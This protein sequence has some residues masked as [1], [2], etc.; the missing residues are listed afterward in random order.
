MFFAERNTDRRGRPP[1]IF[2]RRVRTRRARCWVV[3]R[4]ESAMALLLLAFL[5]PDHLAG[6][7]HALALVGLGRAN[8]ADARGGLTDQ[9]LVDAADLDLDRAG[10]GEADAGRRRDVHIVR[11]AQLHGQRLALQ[12]GAIAD[13]DQF[14]ALLGGGGD[15]DHHVV[16]QGAR[17]APHGPGPGALVARC[18]GEFAVLVLD[19]DLLGHGPGE[20]ALGPGHRDG[21]ALQADGDAGGNGNRLLADPRHLNTPGREFR[22]RHWRLWRRCRSSRL[23]AWRGSRCPGRS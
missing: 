13:A 4:A 20:F 6:V 21:L 10:D 2:L 18:E 7:A 8:L 22:R 12:R 17:E 16:H 3:T 9:L 23:W 1:P 19:H 14:Q 15:P 5:A 11:E